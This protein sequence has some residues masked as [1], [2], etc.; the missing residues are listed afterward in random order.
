MGQLNVDLRELDWR[1]DTVV[2]LPVDLGIGQ[3]NVAVP[4]SVCVTGDL[5]AAAG[6]VEVGGDEVGGFDVDHQPE[7]GTTATP[8][9][10]L[11]AEVDLGHLRIVNDDDAELGDHRRGPFDDDGPSRDDMRE[12]ME[13]ACAIDEPERQAEVTEAR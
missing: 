9:L 10:V 2:E 6:A 11:D 1:P 4:E 13:A 3:L 8:R 7:A 12:A 5:E